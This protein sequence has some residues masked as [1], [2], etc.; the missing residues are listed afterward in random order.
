MDGEGGAQG[1]GGER[2]PPPVLTEIGGTE[3]DIEG[4]ARALRLLQGV[5]LIH[6]PSRAEALDAGAVVNLLAR[7]LEDPAAAAL[8][9]RLDLLLTLCVADG[10]GGGGGKGVMALRVQ[11]GAAQV[12]ATKHTHTHKAVCGCQGS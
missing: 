2:E 8:S 10:G 11:W 9:A 4:E 1:R 5:C 3:A 12:R 7:V 6:A